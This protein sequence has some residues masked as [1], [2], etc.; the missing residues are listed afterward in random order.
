MRG[1]SSW[2]R[3]IRLGTQLIYF[4]NYILTQLRPTSFHP[5]HLPNPPDTSQNP[6][7]YNGNHISPDTPQNPNYNA[8][9]LGNSEE[10]KVVQ[11]AREI[12]DAEADKSEVLTQ[13]ESLGLSPKD[14]ADEQEDEIEAARNR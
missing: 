8:N 14:I 9:G 1:W 6:P 12:A 7:N 2:V 10:N 13:A 3:R 4:T 5:R 11:N